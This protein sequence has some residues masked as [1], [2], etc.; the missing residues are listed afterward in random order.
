MF[1]D[2]DRKILPKAQ[3]QMDLIKKLMKTKRLALL[4]YE[5]DASDC[6][7]SFVAQEI[8]NQQKTKV[9]N[10]EILPRIPVRFKK[11]KRVVVPKS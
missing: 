10:L 3:D 8:V 7:R 4:C 6:H 9:E 2:Y 5:A 1:R 11:S